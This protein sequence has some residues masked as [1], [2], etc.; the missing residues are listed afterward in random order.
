VYSKLGPRQQQLE[1]RGRA[2]DARLHGASGAY[3][4]FQL[5]P[6]VSPM[7]GVTG[8]PPGGA[9]AG[10]GNANG[11]ANGNGNGRFLVGARSSS[12]KKKAAPVP[13]AGPTPSSLS[14][15]AAG[16]GGGG[17]VHGQSYGLPAAPKLMTTFV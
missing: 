10:T 4:Q 14:A 11:N 16:A 17:Y 6:P 3:S 9:A 15:A 7:P 8:V 13:P 5:P 12:A 1:R 2:L